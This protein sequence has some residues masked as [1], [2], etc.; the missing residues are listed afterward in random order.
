[1]FA[2]PSLRTYKRHHGASAGF[3]FIEALVVLVLLGILSAYIAPKAVNPDSLTLRAQASNLAAHI[4]YAQWMATTTGRVVC[5]SVT[6]SDTYK[7]Q[8]DSCS[9]GISTNPPVLITLQN[10]AV[11]SGAPTS[12]S[13]NSQGVPVNSLGT[14]LTGDSN[15]VMN[16]GGVSNTV[17]IAA[18]TGLVTL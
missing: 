3:T 12:I 9:S 14:P 4:Q 15:I 10:N 11:I 5:L 13:F 18:T 2:R 8:L 6:A 7:V 17:N 16:A 1:M